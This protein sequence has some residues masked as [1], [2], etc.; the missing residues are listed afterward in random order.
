[1][2]QSRTKTKSIA[3]QRFVLLRPL[4]RHTYARYVM[5]G[6]TAML[7]SALA[8]LAVSFSTPTKVVPDSKVENKIIT[9]AAV[10][11]I[12]CSHASV[13][14]AAA[15][16]LN[17][18][19]HTQVLDKITQLKPSAV[20][21]LGDLQYDRGAA[22]DFNKVFIPSWQQTGLIGYAVAGNHEY[23]TPQA[24]D[25]YSLLSSQRI[26]TGEQG[27]GYYKIALGEW[28]VFA[29]NSN[30]EFVGGCGT[31]SEQYRWLTRELEASRAKCSMA[32]W[33]HPVFTSGNYSKDL[34][35]LNRM[36]TILKLVSDKGVDVVLNGH[37]HMYERF[38]PMD[39]DGPASTKPMQFTIGTGGKS[40]YKVN[41][42]KMVGSQFT[43]STYGY[44]QFKLAGE[45]FSW[46]FNTLDGTQLDI[47]K[48]ACH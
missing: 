28:D 34:S 2:A 44:V 31:D 10:G 7:V 16:N 32:L 3:K 14:A 11:D 43:A 25:F 33:H 13:V 4:W 39:L 35:S 15:K 8:V 27:K 24:K 22:D 45:S 23:G 5:Y 48:Q 6:A 46:S 21:L 20:L 17:E 18:C 38:E 41:D 30:C 47:G 26:A 9:I 12:A 19:K 1:M 37:D 29:L 42:I 40:L 36:R